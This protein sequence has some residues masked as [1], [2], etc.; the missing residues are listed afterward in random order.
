MLTKYLIVLAMLFLTKTAVADVKQYYTTSFNNDSNN[1]FGSCS[2]GY[3]IC[4]TGEWY[5][6]KYNSSLGAAALVD[7]QKYWYSYGGTACSGG[8]YT[9]TW[10]TATTTNGGWT[11]GNSLTGCGAGSRPILCCED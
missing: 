2:A 10:Q 4:L 1:A 3:H 8:L 5:L 11:M 6:R 9:I 7:G